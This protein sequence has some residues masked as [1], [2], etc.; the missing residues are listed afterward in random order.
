MPSGRIPRLN[1]RRKRET[2][3][4][5][6][7]RHQL[8][9]VVQRTESWATSVVFQALFFSKLQRFAWLRT[10]RSG[11]RISPGAPNDK[12]SP[13]GALF[14]FGCLDDD[15][16]YCSIKRESVLDAGGAPKG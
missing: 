8:C 9:I 11:V 16:D 1:G 4:P 5:T 13:T 7:F 6:Y 14:H 15:E 3:F 12:G 2:A 10:E